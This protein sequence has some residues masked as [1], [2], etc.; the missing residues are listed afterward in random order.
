MRSNYYISSGVKKW[1]ISR[2]KKISIFQLILREA[3]P[4]SSCRRRL[5]PP[6]RSG[7][8]N[9]ER[10]LA[11]LLTFEMAAH[12]RRKESKMKRLSLGLSIQTGRKDCRG[13]ARTCCDLQTDRNRFSEYKRFRRCDKDEIELLPAS[14]IQHGFVKF[15]QRAC[16]IIEGE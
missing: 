5:G 11:F 3:K 4:E 16:A 9:Q 2:P 8:I 15:L 13:T 6:R 1:K 7:A 12:E 14:K 10:R